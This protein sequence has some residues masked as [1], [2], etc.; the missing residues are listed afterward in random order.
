M[1]Y[2]NPL[3]KK[4]IEGDAKEDLIH[5]LL[6]RELPFTEEEYLESLV[7]VLRL[8]DES[9]KNKAFSR[10]KEIS[11]S[12]KATYIEKAEADHRVA[13]FIIQEALNQKNLSTVSIA[14]RNQALPYEFLLKIAEK[15]DSSMLEVLL[16]NQIKLI[17]YPE[18]LDEMEK[19]PEVTPFIKG[20]TKEIREFY[21]ENPEVEEIQE[22]AVMEDVKEILTLTMEKEKK[23]EG[24]GEEDELVALDLQEVEK[25]A[26]TTLQEIN[27][28][29][30]SDRIR[31]AITGERT[32]RMILVKD[33][34]KMVALAVLESPK[35]S[36][37]EIALLAR[38]K[39]LPSELIAKISKKR[40][41]TK[42]YII[43][44]E[45]VQNP[46]TPVKDALS[47][48]KKLYLKD[49]QTISRDK[50]INPVVRSLAFNYY[51][52]KSGVKQ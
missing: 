47:F 3:V 4:I 13:Y 6:Q 10:L 41:W 44:H 7:Y 18:I 38:N 19:N 39:S 12:V 31:L 48:I 33:P 26:K 21:L 34:N 24:D 35:I 1:I 20:K 32:Q 52:Q 37:D 49:L 36:M 14:V 8:N 23:T 15:G 40:D 17:A 46:K 5:L 16:D 2:K 43:I 42:N 28:L 29:S 25:K 50:N 9:L 27:A 51:K 11:D 30:I 22:E 45:L